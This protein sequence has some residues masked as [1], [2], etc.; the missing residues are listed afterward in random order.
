MKKLLR[1][2]FFLLFSLSCV[3]NPLF[4]AVFTVDT[5]VDS[6]DIAP[7]D[8]SC[9]DASSNCSL[10]AAVQEANALTGADSITLPAGIYVLT[11]TGTDENAAATGD[12]DIL[13]ALTINGAGAG[14]T[15]IDGNGAIL[16][17]RVFH[18]LN[19]A[20]TGFSN[21]TI[22]GG[23]L[24]AIATNGT[25]NLS[26]AEISGNSANF[27][28]GVYD[29]DSAAT[30][31]VTI[32]NSTLSNNTANSQGGAVYV[33]GTLNLVNSTL[34]GNSA[35]SYGGAIYGN[36]GAT[37][38][39]SNS[40]IDANAGDWG[41]VSGLDNASI[42]ITDSTVSNSD[43][44]AG[45]SGDGGRGI[46]G[47]TG[48][49]ITITRSTV[50][51]NQGGGIACAA[52]YGQTCGSLT[53][54][55]SAIDGNSDTDS[56][57]WANTQLGQGIFTSG[58]TMITGSSVSDNKGQ[59]MGGGSNCNGA[60]GGGIYATGDLVLINSTITDNGN[61]PPCYNTDAGAVYFGVGGTITNSTIVRNYAFFT[62]G[63]RLQSGTLTITNSILSA[64]AAEN[65]VDYGTIVSG[66][67]NIDSWDNCGFA[68]ATDLVNTDP[69]LDAFADNGGL[70][71]THAL[72]IGSPAIDAGDTTV[73]AAAPVNGAD[74]R[75]FGRDANCDIGAYEALTLYGLSITHAGVG[76]GT[77]TSNTGKIDCQ[78]GSGT[79]SDQFAA[80]MVVTLTATPAGGSVFTG[81]SGDAD[82]SDGQVTMGAPVSCTATFN[83]QAVLT[84]S[85]SP[86]GGGAVAGS[87]IACPGDCSETLTLGN[88]IVLTATT[89]PNYSFNR[90]TNCD[91]PA[92]NRCT[93]TM[94]AD[95]QVTAVFLR[96]PSVVFTGVPDIR[97]TD[98]VAP[99]G[100]LQIPLGNVTENNIATRTVTVDNIGN[101]D[102]QIGSIAQANVLESGFWI[103]NDL[104]SSQTLTPASS[105]T[106]DV[107]FGATLGTYDADFDI[108]SN[109]PDESSL[110]MRV[111]GSAV[112][113]LVPDI[114]ISESLGDANDM[115]MAFADTTENLTSASE[116]LSIANT[117]NAILNITSLQL[118][119]T[120]AGEFILDHNLG[121][122]PCGALLPFSVGAGSS[123][124]IGVTFVPSST[125][126]KSAMIDISS[127]DPDENPVHIGLTGNGLSALANNPP[128][129][130]ILVSPVD[131]Q[132]QS[133]S[134]VS[135]NWRPVTDPDGDQ[136][137]YDVYLCTDAEPFDTCA[138]SDASLLVSNGARPTSAGGL[139]MPG[140]LIL[141]VGGLTLVGGC[142]PRRKTLL[143]WAGLL[144]LANLVA[145]N[146]QQ[147]GGDDMTF[148][149]LNLNSNTT[150]YW[151]VVARDDRGG[152]T[153][154]AIWS[155][156]TGDVQ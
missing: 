105:C 93:M 124:D 40:L 78:G 149:A 70:T 91:A 100:D 25:L 92:A 89:S 31:T 42:T 24:A 45:G 72:Q 130:P 141:L 121:S 107:V 86:S 84:T 129:Q 144:L 19:Q 39:I 156:T 134:R 81:W 119:G 148:T 66:G 112:T 36:A 138:P 16:G 18:I 103:A 82:C 76:S 12:L 3:V 55:D 147:S 118:T 126:G 75:G 74:Q 59:Y 58:P 32:S 9:A 21:L 142:A 22:Q 43:A 136:V 26:N 56:A 37:I 67:H 8:G 135:L 116:V 133:S 64:N 6:V 30:N 46:V 53:V 132:S 71:R 69:L 146:G 127:D 10:R 13:E 2:W 62:G 28:G 17:D 33:H 48:S 125:G 101:G 153:K 1:V 52:A 85:I 4:G 113:A 152:V 60:S 80:G 51:G 34:N 29:Y 5:V 150:Y 90:W 7:G 109:D 79:C 137:S 111:S 11:L 87:G 15:V 57:D 95:K 49:T 94:D 14:S 102:L 20:A 117:G 106:F 98:P 35:G 41:A 97:V 73:C 131:G 120:E 140:S 143:Y 47:W 83:T 115:S 108:P 88:N 96:V 44:V 27:G 61:P 139:G 38:N 77:V 151:G 23:V 128:G 54:T 68:D 63:I 123:C 99:T 50:T 104:C 65:C 145:C 114:E 154:S 155:F 110:V 122:T